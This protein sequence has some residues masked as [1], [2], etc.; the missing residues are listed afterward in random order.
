MNGGE[1]VLARR[2]AEAGGDGPAARLVRRHGL[3]GFDDRVAAQE[4]LTGRD[5]LGAQVL[6]GPFGRRAMYVSQDTDDAAVQ[7]LGHGPVI[8]AEPGF[9]M[10]DRDACVVPGLGGCGR[11]IG[12][13]LDQNRRWSFDHPAN[14]SVAGLA[15]DTVQS[16]PDGEPGGFQEDAGE[17]G[18]GVLAGVQQ[19]GLVSQHPHNWGKLD[20]FRPRA[21]NNGNMR[22]IGI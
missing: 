12:V 6:H 11:G 18:V 17:F 13:A 15:A 7:F 9:H 8:G 20:N 22:A 14:L 4:D 10:Y 5:T 1:D 19:P 3:H 2:D 16:F 21:D